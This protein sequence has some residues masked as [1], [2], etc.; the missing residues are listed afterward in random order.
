MAECVETERVA[1]VLSRYGVTYM[2]GYHFGAPSANRPWNPKAPALQVV[3]ENA[4]AEQFQTSERRRPNLPAGGKV[5]SLITR[6]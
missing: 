5:I 4:T 2:Q 1:E 6:H 3:P